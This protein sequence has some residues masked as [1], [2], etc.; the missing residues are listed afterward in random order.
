MGGGGELI[1]KKNKIALI[2][3]HWYPIKNNKNRIKY[4][5]IF[6]GNQKRRR[7]IYDGK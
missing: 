6:L 3:F 7:M 5:K 1:E 4:K 2:V